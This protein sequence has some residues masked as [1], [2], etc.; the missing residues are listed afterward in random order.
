[1][2]THRALSGGGSTRRALVDDYTQ[3]LRV[4]R[5]LAHL[6]AIADPIVRVSAADDLAEQARDVQKEIGQIRRRAIYEATLRPGHTGESVAAQLHVTPKAVSTAVSEFR[7]RDRQLFREALETMMKKEVTSTPADQLAPGLHARDVLVQ[8]RLV[9]IGYNDCDPGKMSPDEFSLIEEAEKRARQI[10]RAAGAAASARPSWNVPTFTERNV[11]SED[12]PPGM[13][14]PARVFQAL[15]GILPLFFD[16]PDVEEAGTVSAWWRIGWSILPA[17]EGATVFDAGPHRDGWATTEYLIWFTQDMAR[18]GFRI[19]HHI[20]AA[21]P[22][23]NEPGE[24]LTFSVEGDLHGSNA[25][26]P[27]LFARELKMQ[28]VD[29]GTGFVEL[30]WPTLESETQL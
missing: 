27:D 22:F 14:D 7:A 25:I 9:L 11:D 16:M 15:P 30:E 3:G 2:S 5:A 20:S 24:C 26:T 23:L 21:P 13:V 12:V 19:W 28:W 18:A 6:E 4:E 29:Q 17:E 1:M 8:A 10:H